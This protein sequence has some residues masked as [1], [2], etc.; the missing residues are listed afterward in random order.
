MLGTDA[1]G[2]REIVED[3]VTGLLHPIG[4]EGIEPLARN[5]ELLLGDPSTRERLGKNGRLKVENMYM[6][7]HMY[8]KLA[9]AF[10]QCMR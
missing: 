4:R 10:V 8:V 2:T 7:Q 1:G 9:K 5:L 3:G 6:K